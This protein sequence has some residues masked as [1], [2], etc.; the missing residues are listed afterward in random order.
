MAAFIM[1]V[2]ALCTCPEMLLQ[3]AYHIRL[4]CSIVGEARE[5]G[6]GTDSLHS[7]LTAAGLHYQSV[8]VRVG[9]GDSQS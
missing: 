7:G 3:R 5:P 4:G 9:W 6:L 2:L 1:T 8:C